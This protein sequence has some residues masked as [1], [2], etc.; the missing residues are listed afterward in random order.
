MDEPQTDTYLPGGV[1][2]AWKIGS[3]V[4]RAV[5]PWTPAV[6]VLLDFLAP[7]LPHVPHVLGFDEVGREVLSYLPGRVITIDREDLTDAQLTSVVTWTRTFHDV[8]RDFVS[9]GPWRS[10]GPL[11]ATR[12]GH[13]DLAPY[14]LC[15]EGERLSGVF[16]W[17]MAG[18]STP[19]WE[20]AYLAWSCVPL[21]SPGEPDL[22][23][24]RLVQI[25]DIYGTF[26]PQEILNAVPDRIQGM[27]D[28]IPRAAVGGDAGIRHLMARGEPQASR[29]ALHLLRQR[30][31][32]LLAHLA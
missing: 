4:H 26:S 30:M 3:T 28:W 12:I 14:N 29:Q 31:P 22:E 1:G 17:D 6:H 32:S 19:L 9:D 10:P 24:K 27:I 15:F 23:A 25:A 16:D 13:N 20:L 18:P 8:T 5:G 7:R 21:W 2:G 11:G